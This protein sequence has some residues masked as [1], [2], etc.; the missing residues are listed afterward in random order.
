ML[1]E[2]INGVFHVYG[3]RINFKS[4]NFCEFRPD[5]INSW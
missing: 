1:A 5:F 3:V 2:V 4:K